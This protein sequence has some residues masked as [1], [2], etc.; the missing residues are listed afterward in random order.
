[1][2]WFERL[3][4]AGA[5]LMGLPSRL[6][7]SIWDKNWRLY[8]FLPLFVLSLGGAWPATGFCGTEPV[9]EV[10]GFAQFYNLSPDQAGEHLP[11]RIRAT[12][13]C[14]DKGWNQLYLF[15]GATTS[16]INPSALSTNLH[17]GQYVELTGETITTG[18]KAGWTRL[19]LS[20]LGQRPVPTPKPV[21]LDRLAHDYGQWIQTSGRVRVAETSKGRLCLVLHD[22][23]ADCRV[24]VMG[25]PPR[26]DVRTLLGC[27]VSVRGINSS[28]LDPPRIATG[29]ITVSDLRDVRVLESADSA[30]QKPPVVAVD[31]LLERELGPWTNQPVHINGLVVAYS[32]G[33]FIVVKDPTGTIRAEVS[34]VTRVGIEDRVNLWGYLKVS[35]RGVVLSDAYFESV[36]PASRSSE[37]LAS[38]DTN[39]HS[40]AAQ[41]PLINIAQVRDLPPAEVARHTLIRFRGVVT[42][43][44]PQLSNAFVQDASGA[45]YVELAQGKVRPG[46]WVEVA[47]YTDPGG[48]APM[49]IKASFRALGTTNLPAALRVDLADLSSGNLDSHWVEME[50]IVRRADQA[51]GRLHLGLMSAKGTFHGIVAGFQGQPRPDALLGCRVRLQGVCCSDI[52]ERQ[53]LAGVT[54][55]VPD[56]EHLNILESSPADPFSISATP[57]RA[58]GQFEPGGVVGR[59]IKVAGTV[60]L[61]L[62]GEGCFLQ[63]GPGGILVRSA[64]T[65]ELHLGDHV[66]ALGFA[67]IGEFA[68]RLDDGMIRVLGPGALP[69]AKTTS[70]EEILTSGE[71]DS[72]WVQ[73]E[74]TLLHEVPHSAEPKLILQS[75]SVIFV[76]RVLAPQDKPGIFQLRPGSRVR[77]SGVC[78]LQAGEQHQ[79]EAFRLLIPRGADVRFLSAPAWWSERHVRLTAGAMALII[80][81][82]FGWVLSL[83]RQVRRQTAAI[84]DERN[85][86]ATLIDHLPDN[87]YVKDLLGRYV[88]TNRAHARFHGVSSPAQFRGKSGRD[89][90]SA[91]TARAYAEADAKVLAGE[92]PV[93]SREE[94]TRDGAGQTRLLATTKVPLRDQRGQ[95]IGLVG[96][97]RDVTE[98]RRAEQELRE[99]ERALSTLMGNLPGLAFRCRNDPH[100]TMEFLS[101]GCV[102]LTGYTPV[103]LLGNVAK[104]Y[105]EVIHPEDRPRVWAEVQQALARKERFQVHYRILHKNGQERWAWAQGLGV[106][107]ATGALEALEGFV[108]DITERR[109]A[110][111]A[112]RDSEERFRAVWE[113]SIDGMRLSDPEGRIMAVNQAFC[114][115]VKLPRER[116]VGQLFTEVYSGEGPAGVLENYRRSFQ[117]GRIAPRVTTRIQLRNGE[118][119][120]V[121]LSSCFVDLGQQQRAVLS[122]LRDVS[123]RRRVESVLAYERDLLSTLFDNLPDALYFKDRESRFIRASKSKL[124]RS[125]AM[126]RL[127]HRLEAGHCATGEKHVPAA[128]SDEE[129]SWPAHLASL[130]AFGEFIIGKTDF[131]FFDP[132]RAESALEDEREILRTGRPLI[133]KIEQ[134]TH[135]DGR[136]TWSLSTKMPWHDK[137]G[138]LIGTFGISKDITPMKEAE[139]SVELAHRQLV[140]ASRQAGMAEVATGVLHNVGN[141][142]NSVNVSVSLLAEKLRHSRISGVEKV[143]ALLRDHSTDLAEFI[144]HDR[145]GQ[146]LP[147]Y[148]NQLA[149]RLLGEQTALLQEVGCLAKN[150]EHIKT[151]VAMQQS[152]A[153]PAGVAETVQPTELVED[154]LRIN[155]G[156][157]VRGQVQVRREYAPELPALT[158]D[159]HKVLQ[160]LVNLVSNAGHACAQSQRQDKRLTVRLTT[161]GQR[162]SIAVSDNGVGIAPENLTRVFSLGFTTRPNGHG[163]G[164]HSGALAAREIGGTLVSHSDGPGQGATFV[165]E[166]PV[167][168]A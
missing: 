156:A 113:R 47:G 145:R 149:E 80:F 64:Q 61:V 110:D 63:D 130:D 35:S 93:F 86:L 57:T 38:G 4:G 164:L 89:F 122:I 143:A 11:I 96:F 62:P 92:V 6:R 10:T 84:H 19:S 9:Q 139:A 101:E 27:V 128:N 23:G 123:E 7:V 26:A 75:G 98:A 135:W 87:V 88:V 78:S 117:A 65:N 43:A 100:W 12:V 13:L 102:A 166:V 161:A 115:L 3:L 104:R 112:L 109:R 45:V 55:Q 2:K 66:E 144:S 162:V 140:I 82:G 111:Q 146:Q 22:R 133:G 118:Q 68:P 136:V 141:V 72:L 42:C 8:P 30:A 151:I 76:A 121:E 125:L 85:L 137:D 52:N 31:A 48:F 28:K 37:P 41:Q 29:L 70:A 106:F 131:D 155:S 53:Q 74:A 16:Y 81:A 60:T 154:A 116:L 153:R 77:L 67:A 91:E 90:F 79:T 34:Q 105:A 142:L 46:Q 120:D 50:G 73:L 44:D 114:D 124:E 95:I 168:P 71:D 129:A 127:R 119:K 108:I 58:V 39:S 51:D 107:S 1:M 103:E 24:Y 15:D 32:A 158:I 132:K 18:G 94:A 157:L 147:L 134:T 163:F 160:I 54:L 69:P 99:K 17:Q 83:R 21:A 152:Y 138:Q 33:E 49:V 5:L 40:A 14:Y 148:L 150:V 20:E 126:A 25:P 36:Q 56:P 159:K 165:L 97:S 59:R 167:K